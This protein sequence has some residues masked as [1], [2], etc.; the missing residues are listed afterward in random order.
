MINL[1]RWNGSYNTLDEASDRIRI[2][3]AKNRRCLT[4]FNMVKKMNEKY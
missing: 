1:E 3:F 2:Y 4:V